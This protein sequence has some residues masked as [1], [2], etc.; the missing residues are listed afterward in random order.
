M[1]FVTIPLVILPGPDYRGFDAI[2]MTE[3]WQFFA[4]KVEPSKGRLSETAKPLVTEDDSGWVPLDLSTAN[5]VT[6]YEI[7]K[8]LSTLQMRYKVWRYL[9]FR[10]EVWALVEGMAIHNVG[11]EAFIAHYAGIRSRRG[12]KPNRHDQIVKEAFQRSFAVERVLRG[13]E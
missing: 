13:E 2:C 6:A 4:G 7:I 1:E 8:K 11:T 9:N 10:P 12:E 3:N 5:A